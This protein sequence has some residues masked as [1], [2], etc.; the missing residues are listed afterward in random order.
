MPVEAADR[1]PQRLRVAV[2]LEVITRV[3]VE[4]DTDSNK[5]FDEIRD[6]ARARFD[7]AGGTEY[8]NQFRSDLAITLLNT[9][10]RV[11][12]LHTLDPRR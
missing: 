1:P 6:A 9:D 8:R 10:V 2:T 11:G 4:L 12:D 7:R 5:T 3:V